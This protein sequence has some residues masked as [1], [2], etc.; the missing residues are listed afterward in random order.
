[1]NVR[2][3]VRRAAVVTAVAACALTLS[4]GPANAER[5]TENCR[6]A[7]DGFEWAHENYLSAVANLGR[8][9]REA[10]FWLRVMDDMAQATQQL[11]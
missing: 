1:M 11:C 4:A 9:H 6:L 7:V 5:T 10:Y 3:A 8:H 2:T